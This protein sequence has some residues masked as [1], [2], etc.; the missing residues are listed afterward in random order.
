MAQFT[1]PGK[2]A[3]LAIISGGTNERPPG[4]GACAWA[5]LALLVGSLIQ[6]L[7]ELHRATAPGSNPMPGGSAGFELL[8]IGLYFG[9]GVLCIWQLWLGRRWARLLV[10]LWS[11]APVARALSFLSEHNFDPAALMGHPLSFFQA[12]LAVVLLYWLNTPKVR[13]WYRKSSAGAGELISDRLP[14]RLCTGVEFHSDAALWR[15][16]FEHDAELILRCP[17]R[18]VLDDNLAFAS[19]N[20]SATPFF[21]QARDGTPNGPSVGSLGRDA[22]ARAADQQSPETVP[23]PGHSPQEA[24]RLVENLRVRAVRIAR[25]SSDLFVSFEM[26]IELQTW[27]LSAKEKPAKASPGPA[28]LWEYSDPALTMTANA[29]GVQAQLSP[30]PSEPEG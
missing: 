22:F 11:L 28:P 5:L 24:R 17:W 30:G 16:Q 3:T 1:P 23:A 29:S 25:H 19:V 20:D 21:S 15:L 2:A 13:G 14:G 8:W 6:S 7:L 18:I 26:G 9:I 4:I 12:V 10:L 27:G